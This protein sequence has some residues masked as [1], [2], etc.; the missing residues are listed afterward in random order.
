MCKDFF[1]LIWSQLLERNWIER[2]DTEDYLKNF[3]HPVKVISNESL[4]CLLGGPH[5]T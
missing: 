3:W 2:K 5:G 4:M 1:C